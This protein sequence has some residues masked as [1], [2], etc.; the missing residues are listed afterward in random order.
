MFYSFF[1]SVIRFRIA[2]KTFSPKI[3]SNKFVLAIKVHCLNET[4]F[5]AVPFKKQKKVGLIVFTLHSSSAS[6]EN[7]QLSLLALH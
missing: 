6:T 5:L 7:Q 2:L 1:L 3:P 4:Y